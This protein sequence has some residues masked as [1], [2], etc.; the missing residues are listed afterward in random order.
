MGWAPNDKYLWDAWF[1]HDRDGRLHA[2]FLQAS[3]AACD[4]IPSNRHDMA[5]VGHAVSIDGTWKYVDSAPCLATRAASWDNISI[6]TGSVIYD[7]RNDLFY[8][9]YTSRDGNSGKRWTPRGDFHPQRIGVAASKDL[10]NWERIDAIVPNCSED[11]G[12]DG[13]N[14]RDPYVI[15][16]GGNYLCLIS[17]HANPGSGISEDAGGA[18]VLFES[19]SLTDWSQAARRVLVLSDEFYQ[20]EVPQLYCHVEEEGVRFFLL[21]CAQAA[22]CTVDRKSNYPEDCATGTYYF[23]SELCAHDCSI[24]PSFEEPPRLL[25]LDIYAGKIIDMHGVPSLIGFDYQGGETDF[26]GGLSDGAPVIFSD[27][28]LET[29]QS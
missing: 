21:F 22:D 28:R 23:A 1:I 2:F 29:L 12:L 18:I 24:L 20:L 4:F 17:A 3:K 11:M 27:K 15:E 6:W 14:W 19:E 10:M 7:W 16:Y 13:V 26:V 8:M 5:V 25:A 9:F